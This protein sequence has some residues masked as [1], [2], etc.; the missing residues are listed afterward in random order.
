MP[1][2]TWWT[3]RG[4]SPREY[5]YYR[6]LFERGLR[7]G[8]D[9]MVEFGQRAVFNVRGQEQVVDSADGVDILLGREPVQAG[10]LRQVI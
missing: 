5:G 2:P 10:D 4:G 3:I 7:E 1:T 9:F 8:V 6:S